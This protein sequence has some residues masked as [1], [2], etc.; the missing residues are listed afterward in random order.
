MKLTKSRLRTILKE[1]LDR[2][3]RGES[4]LQQLKNLKVPTDDVEALLNHFADDDDKRNEAI[5]QGAL[6]MRIEELGFSGDDAEAFL[7]LDIF[8]PYYDEEAMDF[9]L[10]G[11]VWT[12]DSWNAYVQGRIDDHLSQLRKR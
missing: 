11:P 7:D 10:V 2:L 3:G 12:W 5:S 9:S 8:E 4:V 6:V 1:E